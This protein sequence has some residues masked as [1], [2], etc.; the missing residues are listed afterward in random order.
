VNRDRSVSRFYFECLKG[1]RTMP[2]ALRVGILGAGWAGGG[3]AKAFSL[4]R[5][6]EV[7]AIWSR[8]RGRAESLASELS[9]PKLQ[10]YDHW[11]DLIESAKVDIVS[12]AT[13]P[14]LRRTL[15]DMALE[16]GRHVLVEKP[17]SVGLPDARA[18]VHA[19]QHAATVTAACFNWRYAPG[20]QAAWREIQ[21]GKIGRLLDVR[22][23]W[24]LCGLTGDFFKQR[25]WTM[26]FRIGDGILAEGIIHDF[27]R[28]RFLSGCDFMK[29]V[30]RLAAR[31]VPL[32]PAVAM[33]GGDC[34]VLAELTDDVLGDFR[35][36]LTAGLPE[37]SISFNG[38]KGILM[39]TH[40]AAVRQSIGDAGAIQLNIPLQDRLPKGVDMQQHT[41]NRLIADFVAAIRKGDVT[42][43]SVPHLPI[44]ED[45]LRAQEVVAAA[46][47]S[48]KVRRWVALDETDRFQ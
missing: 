44:L 1:W 45:G 24:R 42:H 32:E 22:M 3:H 33:D 27:D 16:R 8:T 21:E 17:F 47:H 9:N 13:P 15:V 20:C 10:I 6:V 30:S 29:V 4:L 19:A 14:T 5:G 31:R 34:M 28:T 7:S 23:E 37:W 46:R 25:P 48:E 40:E 43:S 38:E 2:D 18:M 39:M 36:T 12:L 26:D 11:Q 35:L 41:W